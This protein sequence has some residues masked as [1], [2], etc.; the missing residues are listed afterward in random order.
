VVKNYLVDEERERRLRAQVE[1][2]LR[3]IPPEVVNGGVMR[4]QAYK[5]WAEEAIRI[6]KN[7]KSVPGQFESLMFHLNYLCSDE[8]MVAPSRPSSSPPPEDDQP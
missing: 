1:S 5:R 2:A 3:R 7:P 4:A 8:F 6:L